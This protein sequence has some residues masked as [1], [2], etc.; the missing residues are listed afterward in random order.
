MRFTRIFL[1]CIIAVAA[2]YGA[3]KMFSNTSV[4]VS[5]QRVEKQSFTP[6]VYLSGSVVSPSQS[7]SSTS[8]QAGAFNNQKTVVVLVGQ[9]SIGKIKLGQKAQILGNGLDDKGYTAVVSSISDTAKKVTL[10]TSKAVVIEVVLKVENPDS[11]LKNGFSAKAKIFTDEPS[12][13]IVAPYSAV[14]SENNK[15]YVYV[16]EKQRAV[17]KEIK[18]DKE[19]ENGYEV[20]SGILE[21]DTIITS[22]EYV[23]KNG[24]SVKLKGEN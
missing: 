8:V 16:V 3:V 5:A 6:Y 1:S 14:F 15:E 2:A 4:E 13:I 17:K 10:G 11:S 12:D 20:V 23:N 9:N 7:A 21:G 18:T 24:D 19:L 22:P